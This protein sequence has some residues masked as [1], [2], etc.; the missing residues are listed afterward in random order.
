MVSFP[1]LSESFFGVPG[2][3]A[4]YDYVIVGG[5]TAGLTLATRLAEANAS[6]AVVEAGGFY[7][8]DN[9][10]LSVVPG[11]A[12]YF[13]GSE[14]NNFQPLIDWGI[15]TT[16]Q[17]AP[18][19]RRLHYARGKTLGG[20]SARNYFLYQ[21]PTIDSMQKWAD[22]VDDD[23]FTWD[24][25]LPYF[26]KSVN[27]TAFSNSSYTNSSNLQDPA[28]FSP[29][30]GP[31]QVSFSNAVDPFGTWA[32]L[33]FIKA[34]MPQ[35]TGL[36]SGKLIGSAYAALT[37]DPTNG[38]RSSSESSFLHAAIDAKLPGLT[39]Y[40]NTFATQ[41][42][43]AS[44]STTLAT[45]ISA[46]TAGT[47]GTGSVE[48]T[49]TARNEV[50][51]SAGAFQSPQ[52]LMVSGIGNCTEL[53]EFGI[54]CR[55]N[56]P[57]VGNNL[58]DHPIFGSARR[59][60]VQTGSASVNN[61]SL[62]ATLVAEYLSTAGGP[63]S[64]FGPGYYGWE[65]LPEPYR[66]NLTNSTRAALDAAFPSDWPEIEWL[67][68]AAYNGDNENKQTADPKDGH[69]YATINACLVA[70]LSRGT[71]KL[72][73]PDMLTLPE[74]NPGW[75]SSPAD[76]DLSVQAF[77][78]QRA[79]WDSLAEMGVADTEEA[80]PGSSVQTDD[81]IKAWIGESM[82]TV[83]HASGTCKMGVAT[84]ASAVVD[85]DGLVFGFENL[86]VVDTSAMPFLTPGHPQSVVYA[87][88][89]RLA[90]VILDQN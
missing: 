66:S 59:V 41:I 44:N 82:T 9:G 53:G 88:A 19:S 2:T 63:L 54:E 51:L 29:S 12:T 64:I 33:A 32:R 78:R 62:A 7:E 55:R 34:G 83:Y 4:T 39:V 13:T 25:M 36:S 11:Y 15:A 90:D 18:I 22:E 8:T 28:A 14:L 58:W 89:E 6:V 77:R 17:A 37:V 69:N 84:D 56:L 86:R 61:P 67:P 46:L 10:N 72:A 73:G 57:G 45:G 5:G 38:Q 71:V 16:E 42:Q 1:R 80:Y 23:S 40:K 35:I 20:S 49:L 47:F 79:I 30:G 85:S 75:L 50:I 87:M 43:F 26:K 24:N 48:F 27:Y 70:P 68:V 81:E 76:L 31:V 52:L 65:K 74:V 3:N 60:N 21:R